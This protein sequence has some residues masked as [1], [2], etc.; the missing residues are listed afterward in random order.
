MLQAEPL[1]M[2]K[3]AREAVW[4]LLLNKICGNEP[5]GFRENAASLE[6]SVEASVSGALPR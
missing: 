2:L 5:G 1:H 6:G 4:S 3:L